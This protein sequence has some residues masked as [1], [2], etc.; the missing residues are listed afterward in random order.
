MRKGIRGY[1]PLRLFIVVHSIDGN[2]LRCAETQ[3]CLSILSSARYIHFCASIDH[4]NAVS[5]WQENEIKRFSWVEHIVNTFLPYQ[6]ESLVQLPS[7]T[8]QQSSYSTSGVKYILESLTPTDIAVLRD[9]A[10]NQMALKEAKSIIE[11]KTVLERCRKKLIVSSVQGMRNALKC[12]EEHGLI[13]LSRLANVEYLTIPFG[14]H[15]IN[16][17]IL[18]IKNTAIESANKSDEGDGSD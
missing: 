12:L 14:D 8:G 15:I 7:S 16:S 18:Q 5:M 4:V 1:R 11:Y 17:A 9:I 2:S 13:K 6:R 3:K 10:E